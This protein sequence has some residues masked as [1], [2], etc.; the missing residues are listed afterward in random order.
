M[1]EDIKPDVYTKI[2]R[3]ELLD[4][5]SFARKFSYRSIPVLGNVKMAIHKNGDVSVRATDLETDVVSSIKSDGSHGENPVDLLIDKKKL[6]DTLKSL[7]GDSVTLE[8]FN[9]KEIPAA[10]PGCGTTFFE[11]PPVEEVLSPSPVHGEPINWNEKTCAKCGYVGKPTE[12]HPPNIPSTLKVGKFFTL[13]VDTNV[14]DYPDAVE[15]PGNLEQVITTD[16]GSLKKVVCATK[17]EYSGF[18][19]NSVHFSSDDGLM[20]ATDSHRMHTANAKVERDVLLEADVLKKIIAGKKDDAIITVSMRPSPVPKNAYITDG[21]RKITM[22]LVDGSFP[23]Y[24]VVLKQEDDDSREIVV[25]TGVLRE[26][27]KQAL[28]LTNNTCMG[29]KMSFNGCIDLGT[30]VKDD[31]Y[32]RTSV[33][34]KSGSVEPPVSHNYNARFIS[35]ILG[36]FKDDVDLTLRVPKGTTPLFFNDNAGF[37]GLVMP[38][39]AL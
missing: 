2:P 9:G 16:V 6:A 11:A 29:V 22:R 35:D 30:V 25:N 7:K 10:C 23:N 4:A 15:F 36:L 3:K 20:V 31:S 28:A 38:T 12:F 39:R 37:E 14:D 19:L 33:E 24:N 1:M 34:I 17:S 18:N 21:N 27:M 8:F 32:S 13:H 26:G 5:V